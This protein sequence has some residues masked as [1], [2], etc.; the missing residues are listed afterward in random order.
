MA[1]R[2]VTDIGGFEA[3]EVPKEERPPLFWQRQLMAVRVHDSNADLRYIVLPM[4]PAGTED[5]SEQQLADL[6]TRDCLVGTALPRAP[7]AA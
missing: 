3:G 4:R 7:G 6:V 5:L 2:L 1:G